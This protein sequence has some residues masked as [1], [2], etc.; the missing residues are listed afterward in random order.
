MLR[1][2]WGFILEVLRLCTLRK[3]PSSSQQISDSKFWLSLLQKSRQKLSHAQRF[4][5]YRVWGTS[6]FSPVS[7]RSHRQKLTSKNSLRL[8]I[9]HLWNFFDF[10]DKKVSALLVQMLSHTEDCLC[11]RGRG[12]CPVPWAMAHVWDAEDRQNSVTTVATWSW[13]DWP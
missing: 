5:T 3:T 8:F 10:P 7:W 4:H 6:S 11:C 1:F 9:I 12:G 13:V 2:K